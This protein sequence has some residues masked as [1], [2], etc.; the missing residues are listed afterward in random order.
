MSVDD[1]DDEDVDEKI[2]VSQS[3]GKIIGDGV[4]GCVFSPQLKCIPNTKITLPGL[5]SLEKERQVSKLIDSESA[6]IEFRLSH[7]ISQIPV[8]RNYFVISE[9]ICNPASQQSDPD[10]KRCEALKMDGISHFKILSMP[11]RGDSLHLHRFSMEQFDFMRFAKHLIEAGSLMNLF[12]IVHRDLHQGN[13]LV[14]VHHV[15]RIIDF[16]LSFHTQQK[17][18][19]SALSHYFEPMIAHEPPD[20]ALVNAIYQKEAYQKDY[21]VVI[22]RIIG[23]KSILKRIRALFGGSMEQMRQELEEF[24][25][26][27]KSA[28]TGDTAT[29]FRTY[30]SKIDS[31]AIGV[32]LVDLI[33]KFLQYSSFRSK[34]TT[35]KPILEP[36]LRD[37]CQ[38]NPMKRIDCVQ[39]LHRLD[40]S[41]FILRKYGVEWL[42]T[43]K[44]V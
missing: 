33:I 39:A 12:N 6:S 40:S 28:K 41:H 37:M 31:W 4:Y 9:S 24:Y 22:Q 27:S 5:P 1:F 32:I 36:I 44:T 8:W 43:I 20:S 21:D 17:V 30:W 11:Y 26:K 3:G 19:A 29:W 16:N 23:K 38:I 14:D 7:F 34:Y 18:S 10:L 15:P 25:Q 42:R 2:E 13:I 35:I